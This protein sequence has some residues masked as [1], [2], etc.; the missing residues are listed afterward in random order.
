MTP[1]PVPCSRSAHNQNVL[2]RRPQLDQHGCHSMR[3]EASK[4][5]R[6]IDAQLRAALATPLERGKE[7][8]PTVLKERM[9]SSTILGI[10]ADA[11]LHID[12]RTRSK[13]RG[14]VC[15]QWRRL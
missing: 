15:L 14:E 13:I 6:T 8:D 2:A 11:L 1:V 9:N 3:E 12:G 7:E 10:L 5:G 4:L